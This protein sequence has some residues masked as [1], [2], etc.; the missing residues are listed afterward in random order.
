MGDRL[1][2]PYLLKLFGG[3]ARRDPATI[4]TLSTTT[5]LLDLR[6][7]MHPTVSR[8]PTLAAVALAGRAMSTPLGIRFMMA[9][10]G[11]RRR[12]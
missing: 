5:G 7:A 11:A 4:E 9:L 12:R 2:A 6:G 10:T 3:N 1:G 8:R